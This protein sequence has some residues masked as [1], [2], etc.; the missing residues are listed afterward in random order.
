MLLHRRQTRGSLTLS[1]GSK[2]A[3]KSA[4]CS[5]KNNCITVVKSVTNTNYLLKKYKYAHGNIKTNPIKTVDPVETFSQG[6][7]DKQLVTC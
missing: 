2:P 7:V 4:N 6:R 1:K 3:G 5:H